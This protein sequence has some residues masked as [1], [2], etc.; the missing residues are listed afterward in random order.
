[1]GM[2]G[3]YVALSKP[4]VSAFP[5]MLLAL[6]RFLIA[7][8]YML[9]WLKPKQNDQPIDKKTH[10]LL[11]AESFL[12]NFLFSICM[13][14]GVSM[15]GASNAAV[16]F[17]A[18]PAAVAIFGRV[19]LNEKINT[20]TAIAIALAMSGIGLLSMQKIDT[21]AANDADTGQRTLGLV[22]L[23]LA[24]LCE[25]SYVVIGKKLT[26]NVSPKRISAIVNLWGLLLVMPFGIW[27]AIDFKFSDVPLLAWQ[28]LV[29]Y[30]LAAS[31]WSVQLWMLG[32]KSVPAGKAGIMT[33]M[34]PITATL[35]GVLVLN[36][37]FSI[38]QALALALAL[39][40]VWLTSSHKDHEWLTRK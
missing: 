23:F 30:A 34:L 4:L 12:G 39:T 10:Q 40:G 37:P 5:V 38:L 15:A 7:A 17:A 19:F 1:M 22:L 36:E 24:V 13:L 14:Y 6:L 27:A 20:K 32:L 33:V 18:I 3:L 9:P 8:I 28:L 35:T 26:A 16:V 25:A 31:A 11:F 2:V 29:F 21:V